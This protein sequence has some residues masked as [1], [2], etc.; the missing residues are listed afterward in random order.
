MA[1]RL[2]QRLNRVAKK[3]SE[4]YGKTIE[5]AI[6]GN[7][8]VLAPL[9]LHYLRWVLFNIGGETYFMYQGIFDTDF[10]KYTEDAIALFTSLGVSTT[11][12]ESRRFPDGLENERSGIR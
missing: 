7:P 3:R 2:L 4:Q 11:S 9:R 10:D 1:S 8:F 5:N 12:R 6:A